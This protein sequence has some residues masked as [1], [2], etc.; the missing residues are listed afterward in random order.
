MRRRALESAAITSPHKSADV[1]LTD[2]ASA[3]VWRFATQDAKIEHPTAEL[4]P[5]LSVGT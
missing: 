1:Y 3:R 2:L 5:E 4:I